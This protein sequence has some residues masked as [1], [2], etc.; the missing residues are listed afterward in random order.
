MTIPA[1]RFP[2]LG[3]DA[4]AI[5][6]DFPI[7][8]REV[9][10]KPLV[11]LDNAAT[12]QKPA[13]VID[14]IDRYYREYNA[15]IHRGVH[16]LSGE[17]TDAAEAA[18]ERI[19]AFLG[20]ASVA[21]IVFTRG[22]TEA[23]NLV[24]QTLMLDRLGPEDEVLISGLEH[25]S[26]IVPWQIACERSGAKLVVAPIND[27]GEIDLEAYR[28]LVTERTRIAAINHV[29]NALGTVNP[30][31]EM[32]A[33]AKAAG[34]LV[35]VDGAQATA[36]VPVDVAEI[37]CD[38]YALSGH[39][40]FGPTGIGVL[41][42]REAVLD[43][44]PPWQGGGD[45]IKTVSFEKTEYNDLPY[46]FEAGTP[47]IA[48]MI[49]MGAAVDYLE[50]IDLAAAFAHEHVLLEHVTSALADVPGMKVV[51]TAPAKTA[52]FS[53]EIDGIHHHDVGVL[54]DGMGIAI[55][56][57]HHCAMPVMTRYGLTGTARASFAMYNSFDDAERFVAGVRRATEM[58]A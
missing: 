5:R 10:G 38:F 12:T 1:E 29:S 36:H 31:V 3:F 32:T 56:T 15:N 43:A 46:K 26:N 48:G 47:N 42:G 55:R 58:L 9:H 22:T 37:G 33:I 35:L 54:L 17:A 45:M 52:V 44:L 50:R 57:G 41:Y 8:A 30:V 14:T 49:G 18:R 13:H 53:F 11:Y 34:A 27:A 40:M 24:A 20:A 39:K 4:D 19:R 6:R 51:G 2:T 7:L 23:I 25:H 28:R 21:E 16:T